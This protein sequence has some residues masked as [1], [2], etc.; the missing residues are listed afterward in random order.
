MHAKIQNICDAL[1]EIMVFSQQQADANQPQKPL[2]EI[3]GWHHPA[4]TPTEIV[5][6]IRDLIDKIEKADIKSL[7]LLN[8][9]TIDLVPKRVRMLQSGQ[10]IQHVFNGN[11]HQALASFLTTLQWVER[12]FDPIFG[13][14]N[15]ENPLIPTKLKRK[16]SSVSNRIDN[17]DVESKNMENII[18]EIKEAHEIAESLPTDIDALNQARKAVE[19]ALSKIEIMAEEAEERSDT[20]KKQSATTGKLLKDSEDAYS[21]AVTKGLSGAFHKRA[22]NL[23]LLMWVWVAGLLSALCFGLSIGSNRL[24]ALSELM[25]QDNPNMDLILI[26]IVLSL[27]GL[28]APIWF[29]WLSTKHI[30][31]NSRLAEDYNFKASVAKAYEGYR[32]E[33]ARIDPVMEAKLLH[34]ALNR[35]DEAPL[36]YVDDSYHATPWQELMSSPEF[37]NALNNIPEFKNRVMDILNKSLPENLKKGIK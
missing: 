5:Q 23:L 37:Q 3:R 9:E 10:N 24:K 30:G 22:R 6:I 15:L 35:L 13:Y 14:E 20:I 19:K 28:G 32:K 18:S 27:I 7:E 11:A 17:L 16:I 2:I 34:S 12:V 4:M 31:Q 8:E 29:A 25:A 21:I 33:A 1:N 26:Q 36:R